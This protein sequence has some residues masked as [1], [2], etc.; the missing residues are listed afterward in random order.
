MHQ[1]AASDITLPATSCSD[2]GSVGYARAVNCS[3]LELTVAA[4][5]LSPRGTPSLQTLELTNPAPVDCSVADV[6]LELLVVPRP[7][8]QL[9]EPSPLACVSE[10]AQTITL[11]GTGFVRVLNEPDGEPRAVFSRGSGAAATRFELKIDSFGGCTPLPNTQRSL[12]TCTQLNVTLT[13][14]EF[15]AAEPRVYSV[16]VALPRQMT[17]T[18]PCVS[19]NDRQLVVV[20]APTFDSFT[21]SAVACVA[22]GDA[23]ITL[24]GANFV[25]YGDDSAVPSIDIV[26]ADSNATVVSL[27]PHTYGGCAPLP[28]AE[29]LIQVC[30]SVSV[31]L[32]QATFVPLNSVLLRA[33]VSLPTQLCESPSRELMIVDKPRLTSSDATSPLLCMGDGSL[34]VT[35]TF[36]GT[37]F[38][39]FDDSADSVIDV[40]SRASAMCL[41]SAFSCRSV[42]VSRMC[43]NLDWYAR[44]RSSQSRW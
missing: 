33:S 14:E 24:N 11:T 30:S 10:G 43:C 42:C 15:L 27:T 9:L 26:R 22:D 6:P 32:A 41:T 34:D 35:L 4:R 19:N 44:Q 16:S 13:Q 29:Q 38:L 37:G 25:R 18:P 21:P 40:E 5:D 17:S 8:M 12:E 3:S 39:T 28:F 7:I 36:S 31:T 2:L 20:P 23:N 1:F